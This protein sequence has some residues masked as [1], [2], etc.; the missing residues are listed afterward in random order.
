MIDGLRML[1]R[2]AGVPL[3]EAVPAA[4]RTPAEA[5]GLDDCGRLETGTRADLVLFDANFKVMQTWVGGT[6]VFHG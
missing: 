5:L 4:T 2:E 1:V 6:K 3:A